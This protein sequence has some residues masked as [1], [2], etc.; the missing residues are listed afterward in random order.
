[1]SS[2]K[3]HLHHQCSLTNSQV[4]NLFCLSKAASRY[5]KT[6]SNVSIFKIKTLSLTY[7]D[8]IF[9]SFLGGGE[10]I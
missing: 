9:G 3:A 1:M 10:S 8:V 6:H 2:L 7:C 4:K 5:E